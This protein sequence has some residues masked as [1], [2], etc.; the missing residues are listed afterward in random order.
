M[1]EVKNTA[2]P[3]GFSS[4]DL[5]A[6]YG[7][8]LA[9]SAGGFLV[10]FDEVAWET[11]SLTRAGPR[12]RVWESA[13]ALRSPRV[14]QAVLEMARDLPRDASDGARHTLPATTIE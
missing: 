4:R 8:N 7:W 12:V 2:G 11:L 5:A 14:R 3:A 9:L 13:F 1:A 6:V 10:G